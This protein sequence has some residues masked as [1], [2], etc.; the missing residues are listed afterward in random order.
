VE[1]AEKLN[2]DIK[3]WAGETQ[4]ELKQQFD[5]LNIQHVDRSPSPRPSREVLE[6]ILRSR[7]GLVSKVSFKFPRHMVFVHKGV[8]KGVPISLAGSNATNRKPKPWFNPVMDKKVE[9]LADRVADHSA[10]IVVNNLMIK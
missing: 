7:G 10:D 3:S 9:D 6:N 1:G 4:K 8:G 5:S 2:S